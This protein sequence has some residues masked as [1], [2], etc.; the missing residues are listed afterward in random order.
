MSSYSNKSKKKKKNISL[1]VI[2]IKDSNFI[3]ISNLVDKREILLQHLYVTGNVA[4]R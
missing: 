2:H 4:D 3:Y 1:G